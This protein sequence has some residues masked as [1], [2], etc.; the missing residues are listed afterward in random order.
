[1]REDLS[2][3]TESQGDLERIRDQRDAWEEG[4]LKKTLGRAP[5]RLP[6]FTTPSGIPLERLYTPLDVAGQT[7]TDALGFPGVG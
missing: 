2:L 5:E 7:Y 3:L 4:V 1:M 6:N